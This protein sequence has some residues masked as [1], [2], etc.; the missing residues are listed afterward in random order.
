MHFYSLTA[1]MRLHQQVKGGLHTMSTDRP[2]G[3]IRTNPF[4]ICYH[5]FSRSFSYMVTKATG[6][7]R[8][9]ARSESPQEKGHLKSAGHK[10]RMDEAMRSTPLGGRVGDRGKMRNRQSKWSVTA[11]VCVFFP[12]LSS[13]TDPLDSLYALMTSHKA[14]ATLSPSLPVADCS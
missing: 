14:A 6:Q 7:C 8:Q 10:A 13:L 12:I 3:G 1:N 5:S 11:Y 9:P 2:S 4:S